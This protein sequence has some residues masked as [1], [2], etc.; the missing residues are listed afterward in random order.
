MHCPSC[1][2]ELL[3]EASLCRFCGF[4]VTQPESVTLPATGDTQELSPPLNGPQ[5]GNTPR[6]DIPIITR[7]SVIIF[8]LFGMYCLYSIATGG[9]RLEHNG[10]PLD[11]RGDTIIAIRMP[12][13]VA[14]SQR[15]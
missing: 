10:D 15:I 3:P 7:I 5:Y 1:N 12:N 11:L 8:V 14:L 9:P 6:L 13:S 4:Y 2:E